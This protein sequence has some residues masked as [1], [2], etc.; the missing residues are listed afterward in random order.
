MEEENKA[1]AKRLAAAMLADKGQSFVDLLLA[2]LVLGDQLEGVE[3]E[4]RRMLGD[5]LVHQRL[6]QRRIIGL[7]VPVPTIAP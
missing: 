2:D 1:E 6:R 4:D 7:V 3:M 5:L